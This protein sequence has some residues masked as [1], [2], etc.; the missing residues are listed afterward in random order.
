MPRSEQ[1]GPTQNLIQPPPLDWRT[2]ILSASNSVNDDVFTPLSRLE[3]EVFV[4]ES[5]ETPKRLKDLE[6]R[7]TKQ[8]VRFCERI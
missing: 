6:E 8:R 3:Q 1:L 7:R 4:L 2:P 5:K